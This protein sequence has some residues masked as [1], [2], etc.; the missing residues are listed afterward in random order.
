MKG[1]IYKSCVG[2]AMLYRTEPG[3]LREKEI[4]ILQR[5]ERAMCD[6]N[7]EANTSTKYREVDGRVGCKRVF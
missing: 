1:K 3:C 5:T 4:A 6:V 7:C 2:A